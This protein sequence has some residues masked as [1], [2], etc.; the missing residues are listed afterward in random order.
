[1]TNS[2]GE[3]FPDD[4]PQ[5]QKFNADRTADLIAAA[6]ANRGGDAAEA[7]AERRQA[8]PHAELGGIPVSP[9][10]DLPTNAPAV[11]SNA[12]EKTSPEDAKK[13]IAKLRVQM[14]FH[15]ATPPP[16]ESTTGPPPSW[17]NRPN[18]SI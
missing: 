8:G 12:P 6:A 9:P 15:K 17:P 1:M 10:D 18:V 7:A 4:T 5:A 3:L 11:T 2:Q 16:S 13:E 14:G